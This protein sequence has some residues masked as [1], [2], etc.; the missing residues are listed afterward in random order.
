MIS[1]GPLLL[2]GQCLE[3]LPRALVVLSVT[4]SQVAL[5]VGEELM[6]AVIDQV[7]RAQLP[8]SQIDLLSVTLW[9]K[10]SCK[11]GKRGKEKNTKVSLKAFVTVGTNNVLRSAGSLLRS[12][13]R[14]EVS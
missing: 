13:H 14:I 7:V 6:R 5:G 10:K 1:I 2:D 4:R 3:R 9:A 11:K 12:F 8:I